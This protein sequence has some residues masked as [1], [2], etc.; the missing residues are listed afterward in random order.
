MTTFNDKLAGGETKDIYFIILYQRKQKENK[1]GLIFTKSNNISKNPQII[2]TKEIK[3]ENG[4][5]FYNKVFK[6]ERNIQDKNSNNSI[7]YNLIFDISS[8]KYNASFDVKE[9]SFIYDV[10]LKSKIL[11]NNEEIIDQN[12]KDYYSKLNIFIESLKKN[13]EESKIEKLYKETI[14]LHLDNKNFSFLVKLFVQIYNNK[15]WCP[16]LME[17]FKEMNIKIKEKEK[18]LE[19]NKDLENYNKNFN[20]I[21]SEADKLI[22]TNDYDPIQFYGI[23]L[24]YLNNYDNKNFIKIFNKLFKE[25]LEVLYEIL[26]IYA[27]NLNSMNQKL[28]LNFFNKFLKY[29][30][31]KKE[32]NIFKNG[33]KYIKEIE[34]FIIVIDKVKEQIANNYQKNVFKPISLPP[35]KNCNFNDIDNIIPSIESIIDYSKVN[36]ILLIYF[37]TNFWAKILKNYNKINENDISISF[38][39]RRIFVKYKDLVNSL[40]KNNKNCK[41]RNDI[42]EYYD[43]DEFS[44]LLDK[45]I[46]K[47]LEINKEMSNTDIL[48]Y[49][50]AFNPYY[51]EERYKNNRDTYILDYLNMNDNNNQFV[52][53][54]RK[55]EFEKIFKYNI[56]EFLKK[57]ISKIRNIPNFGTIIDLISFKN[58]SQIND[59]LSLLNN[60]YELVI[61]RQIDTLRGQ[62]VKDAIKII[63]K[64]LDLLYING[65]N[66]S[67]LE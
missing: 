42:N 23:I 57:M 16:L 1:D 6:L 5:F 64:F 52:K 29:G 14:T 22:K 36:K 33:L 3:E 9:N 37:T 56:T 59:Y 18:N 20:Q 17:K 67:F 54:F 60:K 39:L 63:A 41:I 15:K 13:N 10:E 30:A 11:N 21:S 50:Q 28:D 26:L 25:N 45:N 31:T 61:K 32:F 27:P 8:D 7:K 51:K 44:F 4:T 19:K 66:I 24:C 58:I 48:G 62:K 40:Y 2:Y 12:I 35:I 55:F 53:T 34:T 65:K 43:K 46:R 49:V 47:Y 38:N